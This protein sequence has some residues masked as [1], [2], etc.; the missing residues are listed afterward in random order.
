MQPFTVSCT[1]CGKSLKVTKP[2]HI[3]RTVNCP[4]C[5]Q[6]FKIEQPS[7]DDEADSAE[8]IAPESFDAQAAASFNAEAPAFNPSATSSTSSYVRKQTSS[9]YLKWAPLAGLAVVVV[10]FILWRSFDTADQQRIYANLSQDQKARVDAAKQ[11]GENVRL[12]EIEPRRPVEK[13]KVE[14]PKPK[15]DRPRSA[16]HEELVGRLLAMKRAHKQSLEVSALQQKVDNA[17][18]RYRQEELDPEAYETVLGE[19]AKEIETKDKELVS[20]A[21]QTTLQLFQVDQAVI[22]KFAPAFDAAIRAARVP[23][24]KL[25]DDAKRQVDEAV[26]KTMAEHE[27]DKQKDLVDKMLEFSVEYY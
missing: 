1:A 21:L 23:M 8:S 15:A 3:G 10:G 12:E 20:A 26:M 11:S 19:L 27:L 16:L 2:E 13:P 18:Y 17:N 24:W 9:P 22:G 4:G 7:G 14:R 6:K 25:N 5:K